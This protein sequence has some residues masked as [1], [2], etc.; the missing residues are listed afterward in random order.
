VFGNFAGFDIDFVEGFDVLGDEGDRDDE[1]ALDAFA[2]EAGES[3]GGGGLEPLHGTDAALEAEG[4]GIGPGAAFDD[5][6]DGAFDLLGVGVAFFHQ[7]E[8]NAVCAEDEVD[9]AGRIEMAKGGVDA[10]HEGF[11]VEG[12]AVEISDGADGGGI[13][14]RGGRGSRRGRGW[15]SG[16]TRSG[17]VAAVPFFE[18]A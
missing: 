11:D 1:Y 16:R 9:F 5:G 7:A 13:E 2:A 14:S 3:R 15:G 8:G 18:A 12:M 10:V 6:A 17:T 4:V